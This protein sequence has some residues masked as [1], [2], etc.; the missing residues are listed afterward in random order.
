ME[1]ISSLIRS[2]KESGEDAQV[3]WFIDDRFEK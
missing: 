2:L 3:L 1:V